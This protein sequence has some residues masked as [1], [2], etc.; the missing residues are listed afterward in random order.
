MT[1]QL[2]A[3]HATIEN[4]LR[5][6]IREIGSTDDPG[7]VLTID[8]AGSGSRLEAEIVHWSRV[9]H[10]RFGAVTVDGEQVEPAEL[11]ALFTR[12]AAH[13][14]GTS[15]DDDADLVERVLDSVRRV[16]RHLE[17][18]SSVVAR[19]ASRFLEAEQA[20]VLGHPFHPSAKSRVA[21][22]EEEAA[23]Y[24]P[25]LRGSFPLHWFAAHES[26]V[27][28]DSAL[29]SPA[30]QLIAACAPDLDVPAGFTA[31]P[32]HPWQARELRSRPY[33]ARLIDEGD[34]VDLG[35]SG[36]PWYP[37]SSLRTVYH[38]D[39]PV[40]M[41][42][43]L[44]LQIT[45]SKRENLRK[46]LYRG[47]EIARLLDAGI[48][49]AF[50]AAHP[51]F[52][53]VGDPAWTAVGTDSGLDVV[54]RENPFS[55]DADVACVAGLIESRLETVAP[56]PERWLRAYVRHVLEPVF[57]LYATYGLGLE[58]HQQNTL[59]VLDDD[60]LPVG[61]CYRDNQ[62]YYFAASRV[63]ELRDL[64][65]DAG[66]ASDTV[67]PDEVVDERLGYYIGVNNLLGLI[68]AFGSRGMAEEKALLVAARDEL[69]RIRQSS[70]SRLLDN[71]LDRPT[72][73]SKANLLTRLHGMDELVGPV[74]TQS[75][76]VTIDNPLVVP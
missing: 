66:K 24:S 63:A 16:E 7:P 37:T 57:W 13:R 34:L 65:A 72:L 44:G 14:Q 62:G 53:I 75:V 5:C 31:V 2:R 73:R 38:P 21:L 70:P 58:A 27:E 64:L 56:E 20:L 22:D 4:L 11:A 76:Y 8:L 25:E 19:P 28:S 23:L 51:N 46:E 40:M 36:P 68:G 49:H 67:V 18:R 45:N 29:P 33:I 55:H 32:A 59:V 47:V 17:Q 42:L 74:A 54:L 12:E 3:V 71:L 50:G 9:G 26:V 39:A 48:R 6:W 61:G 35:P 43:S 1:A 41:K 69:E 15:L 52:R 60:G 10:H 30:A